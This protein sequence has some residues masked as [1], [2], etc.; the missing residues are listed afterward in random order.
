MHAFITCHTRMMKSRFWNWMSGGIARSLPQ[1]RQTSRLVKLASM[2]LVGEKSCRVRMTKQIKVEPS[3]TA[4][5]Q[6]IEFSK[7]CVCVCV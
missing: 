5:R 1:V 7:L 6:K 4:T 2:I 3:P